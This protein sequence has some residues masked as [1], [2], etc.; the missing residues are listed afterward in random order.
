MVAL[1]RI[2]LS[3]WGLI[4]AAVGVL[5]GVMLL[6]ADIAQS[7]FHFLNNIFIY[8]FQLSFLE[9]TGIWWA[10]LFGIV[11]LALGLFCIVVALMPRPAAKKLRVSTV[12]GGCV[13]ISLTALHQMIVR[14]A[15]DLEGLSSIDADLLVKDNGL[16]VILNIRV[17]EGSNIAQLGAEAREAVTRQLDLAAAIIPAEVQVVV[18]DVATKKEVE[19]GN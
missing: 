8:N 15:K 6:N 1:R 17:T 3:L 4:C 5:I 7:V 11:L 16:H 9:S 12:D 14:S 18:T 10:I 2:L 13:D 19:N